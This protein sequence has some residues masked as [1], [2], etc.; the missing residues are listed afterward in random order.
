MRRRAP[1]EDAPNKYDE[2]GVQ[3]STKKVAERAREVTGEFLSLSL[4]LL[5]GGTAQAEGVSNNDDETELV[6]NKETRRVE[7]RFA[8]KLAIYKETARHR[9]K[10][11]HKVR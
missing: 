10:R 8:T 7:R 11:T 1:A 2:A 4:F 6:K 3:E 5:G 9:P